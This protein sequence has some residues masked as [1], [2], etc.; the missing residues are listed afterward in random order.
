MDGIMLLAIAIMGTLA[1]AMI[2][3]S[4]YIL[5]IPQWLIAFSGWREIAIAYPGRRVQSGERFIFCTVGINFMRYRSCTIVTI[6]DGYVTIACMFPF[7]FYH[8]PISLPVIQLELFSSH[9]K[10]FGLTEFKIRDTPHSVWLPPRIASRIAVDQSDCR[11][12]QANS[13]GER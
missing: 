10:K 5:A 2:V 13:G 4:E 3:L 7:R 8:P 12:W 6:D 9:V 1:V 11:K